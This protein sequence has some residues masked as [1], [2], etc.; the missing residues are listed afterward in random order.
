MTRE[1]LVSK[2]KIWQVY[3]D[4]EPDN[5]LFEGCETKCKKYIKD[6]YGLK[7]YTNGKI[8]LAKVIWEKD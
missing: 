6:N 3:P 1:Q 8:R 7:N 2:G 4:G 5:V